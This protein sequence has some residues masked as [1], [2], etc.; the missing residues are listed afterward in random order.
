MSFTRI[1]EALLPSA[2]LEPS[3]FTPKLIISSLKEPYSMSKRIIKEERKHLV[4]PNHL[5]ES[6]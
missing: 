1:T 3:A 2:R 5:I 4:E 6:P